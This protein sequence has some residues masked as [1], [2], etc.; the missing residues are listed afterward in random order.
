[1]FRDMGRLALH[2]EGPLEEATAVYLRDAMPR[3]DYLAWVAEDEA[4]TIVGGAGVHLR[5]ILPRADTPSALE[6][7]PEALIVNVYVEQA[8]RRRGV[9]RALMVAIL[10]ALAARRISRVLL[11]ASEEGRRL[12]ESLG[13]TP[14]N[15]MRLRLG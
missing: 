9:A 14:T 5:P 7:G 8:W 12:Y 11:H 15:E 3:G 1:M 4:S 10:D 6:F 2:H 13:F